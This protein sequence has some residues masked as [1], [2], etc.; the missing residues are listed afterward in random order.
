MALIQYFPCHRQ[1]DCL[2]SAL[3]KDSFFFP[4][5]CSRTPVS[6]VTSSDS[7]ISIRVFS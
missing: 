1:K 4:S 7:Y 5:Q 3:S 2:F 6:S